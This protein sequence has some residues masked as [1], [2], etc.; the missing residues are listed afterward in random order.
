MK[1]D[2]FVFRQKTDYKGKILYTNI[3]L[4]AY[5]FLKYYY[6]KNIFMLKVKDLGKGIAIIFAPFSIYLRA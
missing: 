2:V 6:K 3:R 1:F 5:V 4:L